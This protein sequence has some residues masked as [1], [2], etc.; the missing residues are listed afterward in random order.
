M[1]RLLLL[2]LFS[3]AVAVVTVDA[4]KCY[5]CDSAEDYRCGD[6]FSD[7]EDLLVTCPDEDGFC[8]KKNSTDGI[9]R[10]CTGSDGESTLEGC[11]PQGAGQVV[12]ISTVCRSDGCNGSEI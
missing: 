12:F 6:P 1:P 8:V 11:V 9:Q 2:V 7:P 4:I 10:S 5:V 3:A